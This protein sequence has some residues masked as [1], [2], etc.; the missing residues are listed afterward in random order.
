[1]M[2][3]STI[4][5]VLQKID[6]GQIDPLYYLTGAEK[7]FHDQVIETLETAIFTDKGSRDL[8][9]TVL[10]GTE[11]TLGELLSAALS[12]PMLANYKLVI[13]RDFDKMKISDAESLNKYLNNLQKTTCL[14]LSAE[15][16]GRAKI[17]NAI[18]QAAHNVDCRPIKDY[19]VT[20]W[21]TNY[22]RQQKINIDPQAI[23]FLINQVGSNLLTL[24]LELKKARDFKNDDSDITIED[25]EQTTGI[26]KDFSIFALQNALAHKQLN[27]AIKI[28]NNLLDAGQ[29]INLILS[30]L[31]AFFRK[32]LIASSL[33]QKGTNRQQIASAMG[34]AEFQFKEIYNALNKFNSKQIHHILHLL[35][36]ADIAAKTSMI[37]EKPGL[38]MLC[39]KI[40]RI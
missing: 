35:H 37:D 12:Y 23:N 18:E 13:V 26:S 3:K 38:Q 28:C 10:Y 34:L 33:N 31:Y 24:N 25:L 14:V 2:A 29:N 39:Y 17:Y 36:E 9:L 19:K 30:I 32:I 27:T 1:M 5:Q 11:N 6:S 40:C 8:N 20:T 4:D 21:F 7:F 15:E 22:C 16:K